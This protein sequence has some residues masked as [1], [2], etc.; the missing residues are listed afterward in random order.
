MI[1]V[2]GACLPQKSCYP[3]VTRNVLSFMGALMY[4]PI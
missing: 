2:S 3:E 4:V 1:N